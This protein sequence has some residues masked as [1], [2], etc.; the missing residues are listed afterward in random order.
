VVSESDR[1][2]LLDHKKQ[3]QIIDELV[4]NYLS[5]SQ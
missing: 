3:M 4:E 2:L 5:L 1:V